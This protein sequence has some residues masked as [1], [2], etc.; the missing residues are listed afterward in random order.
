MFRD[1]SA[2][3]FGWYGIWI[4]SMA[5]YF[6]KDG[7]PE[8]GYCDGVNDVTA[9]YERL[10]TWRCERGAEVVFSGPIQLKDFIAMDNEKA[11]LEFVEVSGDYGASGPGAFGGIVVGHSDISADDEDPEYCTEQGVIGPKL[12][13]ATING[14]AFY[15]FDRPGCYAMGTCAQCTV[16]TSS[17]SILVE[18]V[19][20]TNSPN[21]VHIKGAVEYKV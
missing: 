21:K 11:G 4:F 6:P 19:S 3:T 18:D 7:T 13:A 17:F 9:V 8:N 15:N 2:H 10:T 20:F 12:F 16:D 14:T 5:G 1:N